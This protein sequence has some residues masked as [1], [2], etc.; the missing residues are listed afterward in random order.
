MTGKA[1]SLDDIEPGIRQNV[2]QCKLRFAHSRSGNWGPRAQKT[3]V[4]G[5]GGPGGPGGTGEGSR[6]FLRGVAFTYVGLSPIRGL[7]TPFKP[8][9]PFF[10]NLDTPQLPVARLELR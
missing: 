5:P 10:R 9:L 3:G 1:D 7:A 2:N 8:N 6:A 4:S